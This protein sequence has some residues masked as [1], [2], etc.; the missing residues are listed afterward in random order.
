L[1]AGS[2]ESSF[3]AHG[4][5]ASQGAVRYT[6]TPPGPGPGGRCGQEWRVPARPPA[7]LGGPARAGSAF[8]PLIAVTIKAGIVD[9]QCPIWVHWSGQ[10]RAKAT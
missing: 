2:C 4:P 3:R 1:R 7:R 5:A 8:V 9:R 6:T 10:D